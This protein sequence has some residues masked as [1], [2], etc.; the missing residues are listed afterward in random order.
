MPTEV[1]TPHGVPTRSRMPRSL[2]GCAVISND[3]GR[4]D[5][6][7]ALKACLPDAVAWL[8]HGRP[9]RVPP[10]SL[11]GA[12]AALVLAD[13]VDQGLL[14]DQ[15]GSLIWF[16]VRVGARHLADAEHRLGQI[17]LA[18]ASGI[19]GTQSRLVGSLQ[20]PLVTGDDAAAAALLRE[21]APTYEAL[22]EALKT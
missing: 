22:A 4:V 20:Y 5:P 6:V 3:C 12:D 21:L 9:E 18:E 17:G 1:F 13:M 7:E 16:A 14:P 10:G 15:R 2:T 11:G 19:A 8:E